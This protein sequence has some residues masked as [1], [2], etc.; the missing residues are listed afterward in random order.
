MFGK[1]Q[2]IDG[3]LRL[4]GRGEGGG[5]RVGKGAFVVEAAV[6]GC[7]SRACTKYSFCCCAVVSCA[8]VKAADYFMQF[9][10]GWIADPLYFGDYP[11]IM[12]DTQVCKKCHGCLSLCILHG[13]HVDTISISGAQGTGGAART[14]AA[15]VER[16][17]HNI[18]QLVVIRNHCCA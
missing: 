12:R 2:L 6:S 7:L 9:Q 10:Y 3:P 4:V 1:T 18:L 15:N 11:K 5:S 14:S 17:K 8:D 13:L 16:D